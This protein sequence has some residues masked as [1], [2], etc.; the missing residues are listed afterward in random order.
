MRI[1]E[2]DMEVLRLFSEE[3]NTP[4]ASLYRQA[5]FNAFNEWKL[6]QLL[7]MYEKGRLGLKKVWKLIFHSI[8][9]RRI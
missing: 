1:A 3:M 2:E 5:T 4:I 8:L 6:T 9:F 7:R